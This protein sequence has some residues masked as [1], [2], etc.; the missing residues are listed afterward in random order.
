M[1]ILL[2]LDERAHRRVRAARPLAA[3]LLALALAACGR[4]GRP[5][6]PI[7]EG[8]PV[9]DELRRALETDAKGAR[10]GRGEARY[11]AALALCDRLAVDIQRPLA[12]QAAGDS[13]YAAWRR[14]P[15]NFLWVHLG[16]G[17][18]YLLRR[19]ADRNAMYALPALA[20]TTTAVGSFVYGRRFYGYGS[21]GTPYERAWARRS[22]LD[23]LQRAWLV[24]NVAEVRADAGDAVGAVRLLLA[25]LPA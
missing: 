19:N 2:A 7:L 10:G 3:L 17:Y 15:T 11:V 18:N 13:L 8:V 20:D 16:A 21:D 14:D 5:A 1:R 23:S 4:G 22:E 9:S 25:E 12:R 24:R 6:D